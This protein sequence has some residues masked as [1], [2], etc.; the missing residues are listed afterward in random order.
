MSRMGLILVIEKSSQ[1]VISFLTIVN[2]FPT[3]N[4]RYASNMMSASA[5]CYLC[6]IKAC[7]IM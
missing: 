3:Y 7:V 5:S 6:N 2:L 1:L 4:E